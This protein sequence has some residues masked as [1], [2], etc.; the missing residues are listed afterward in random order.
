V[1]FRH[2]DDSF[3]AKLARR[4]YVE[5]GDRVMFY[6]MQRKFVG[7]VDRPTGNANEYVVLVDGQL[8]PSPRVINPPE[9]LIVL[10]VAMERVHV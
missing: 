1:S 3:H 5:I 10:A 4:V 6:A 2:D 8:E 7:V 9:S